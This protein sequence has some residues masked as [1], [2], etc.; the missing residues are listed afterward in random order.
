[1]KRLVLSLFCF[2]AL[3]VVPLPSPAVGLQLWILD[4]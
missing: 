4:D 2:W 3:L 1:V